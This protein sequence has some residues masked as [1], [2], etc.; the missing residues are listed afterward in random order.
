MFIEIQEI[1]TVIQWLFRY[2]II[3]IEKL[4]SNNKVSI[5]NYCYA[6]KMANDKEEVVQLI[7]LSKHIMTRH[8][9]HL[10]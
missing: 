8:T 5:H 4:Y 7:Y 1:Y 2:Y 9:V 3:D 6:L 10:L